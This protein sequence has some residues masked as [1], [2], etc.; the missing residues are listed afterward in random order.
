[1]VKETNHGGNESYTYE[2]IL[3]EALFLGVK[4]RPRWQRN[5][6]FTLLYFTTPIK[7]DSSA[8]LFLNLSSKLE[9]SNPC[10]RYSKC[11]EDTLSLL[12]K[13]RA[14]E[15]ISGRGSPAMTLREINVVEGRGSGNE[16]PER[17]KETEEIGG[18]WRAGER[19]SGGQ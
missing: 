10:V 6:N 2:D 11:S 15:P 19:E 4:R 3:D 18:D 1:M 14:K 9:K 17:R 8:S 13:P 7:S 16:Q 12:G 5:I